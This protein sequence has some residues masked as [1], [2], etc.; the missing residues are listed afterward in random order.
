MRSINQ[1]LNETPD[2]I[3]QGVTTYMSW[4][5][6]IGNE[7]PCLLAGSMEGEYDEVRP[8]YYLFYDE[9]EEYRNIEIVSRYEN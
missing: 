7:T 9:I 1:I 3:K 5:L 8:E 2:Y 4:N 6:L